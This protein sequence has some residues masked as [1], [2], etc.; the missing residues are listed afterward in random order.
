MRVRWRDRGGGGDQGSDGAM[1]CSL[2]KREWILMGGRV[3]VMSDRGAWRL[4]GLG[5]PGRDMASGNR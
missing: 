3:V 5:H 1:G 4:F 2:Y